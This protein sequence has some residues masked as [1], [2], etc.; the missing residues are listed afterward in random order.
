MQNLA[1][2]ER[3]YLDIRYVPMKK[4]SFVKL[5][6]HSMDFTNLSNPRVV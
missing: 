3:G 5:Q 1:V 6:P 4:G 2:Q